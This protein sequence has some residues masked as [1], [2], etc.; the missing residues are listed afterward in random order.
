MC[1][2]GWKD[3]AETAEQRP[4][5]SAEGLEVTVKCEDVL[6]EPGAGMTRAEGPRIEHIR[7]SPLSVRRPKRAAMALG[8]TVEGQAGG[9][10]CRGDQCVSSSRMFMECSPLTGCEVGS[11]R[12]GP[13]GKPVAPLRCIVTFESAFPAAAAKPRIRTWAEID[14]FFFF[15]NL[16]S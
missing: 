4:E 16:S 10:L 1:Q 2:A 6:W 13:G 12:R 14:L 5:G 7:L 3:P 9:A 11:H 15:F 8:S